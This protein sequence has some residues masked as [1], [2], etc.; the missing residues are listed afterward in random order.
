MIRGILLAAIVGLFPGLMSGQTYQFTA[1]NEPY[2]DLS[3]GTPLVTTTWDDPEFNVP[4]GFD[5]NFFGHTVTSLHQYGLIAYPV[6]TTNSNSDTTGIFFVFGADL[7]D[8]GFADTLL[9]SPITYKTTGSAGHRICTIEWKNAGFYN[10]YFYFGGNDDFVNFQMK[11]YQET[12]VIEYHFGPSSVAIPDLV[13]DSTGAFVGF[14]EKLILST[15]ISVGENLLLTGNPSSPNVVQNYINVYLNGTIPANTLYTF[16]P[17]PS[18]THQPIDVTAIPFFGPIPATDFLYLNPQWAEQLDP[19][20]YIYNSTG[21]VVKVEKQ[22]GPIPTG[23]LPSG[24]YQLQF[25]TK[26][27]LKTQRVV[28]VR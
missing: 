2:N 5:F 12:G 26:S 7:I 10:E 14:L 22:L 15:D 9:L 3:N 8:R 21:S 1:S 27:G 17:E 19:P 25:Q 20:V 18:A 28:I 16:T 6:L 23:D 4:L 24:I 11:L 13:Y